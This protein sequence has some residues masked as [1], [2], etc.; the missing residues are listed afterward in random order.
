MMIQSTHYALN[1]PWRGAAIKRQSCSPFNLHMFIV[2]ILSAIAAAQSGFSSKR[3]LAFS[4]DSHESDTNLLLSENSSLAWYYTWS[5]NPSTVIGNTL[6]FVPLIHGLDDASSTEVMQTI[7]D[8]PLS[9]THL[10]TFNEPDGT[11]SSGGSSI[12]PE[13]AARAYISDI[14]PLRS[15]TKS[16]SRS[17]NISHPVVTG[18][19]QGLKWLRSFNESCYDIDEDNGCPTDF[20]AVH[21]YG[22]A[23][24]MESWLKT[25][26][27]FYGTRVSKYWV[28][29]MALPQ[30]DEDD[31]LAT[32]NQSLAFLDAQDDVEA[33]AWLGAFRKDEANAWT[34]DNVALFNDNGAL[35]ELGALY[36]GGEERGFEKGMKGPASH[37]AIS[38]SAMLLCLI[39]AVAELS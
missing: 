20:V 36:L 33:Y 11:T 15:P 16:R 4:G 28:T 24:D 27:D 6:V 3:G 14:V 8:L 17:W 26:H 37:A 5:A 39:L 10:L 12:S 2:S 1:L 34:G 13:D 18:S 30:G 35:T 32:M 21:W 29:E 23:A 19:D 9:S 22:Y 31:T 38:W 7:N 25:L